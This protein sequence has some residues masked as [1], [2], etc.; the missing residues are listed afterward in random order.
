MEHTKVE[1]QGSE[2][3]WVRGGD[4]VWRGKNGG[5]NH[6]DVASRAEDYRCVS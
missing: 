1:E 3:T 6:H 2:M 5:K 4:E